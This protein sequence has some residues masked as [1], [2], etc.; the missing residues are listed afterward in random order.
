M[1]LLLFFPKKMDLFNAVKTDC[2]KY[3]ILYADFHNHTNKITTYIP[4]R[5]IINAHF[6]SITPD[7][8]LSERN[9]ISPL[10]PL[11]NTKEYLLKNTIALLVKVT[12]LKERKLFMLVD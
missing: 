5:L 8:T 9:L 10:Y 7:F 6:I 11:G 3:G 4:A 2:K 1:V 12:E